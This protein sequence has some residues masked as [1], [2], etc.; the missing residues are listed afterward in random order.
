MALVTLYFTMLWN[1]HDFLCFELLLSIDKCVP[2][3][4][5]IIEILNKN[6]SNMDQNEQNYEN[7]WIYIKSIMSIVEV[8][9]LWYN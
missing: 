8:I 5:K 2:I 4:G 7:L 9:L 3:K 6:I 1:S